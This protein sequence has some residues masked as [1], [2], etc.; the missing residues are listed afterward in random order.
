MLKS[1]KLQPFLLKRSL[2]TQKKLNQLEFMYLNP[3]LSVFLD[4]T[5]VAIS[6]KKMLMSAKLRWRVTG[7]IFFLDLL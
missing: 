6:D 3:I 5:K 2:K 4:K 1:S 7:F